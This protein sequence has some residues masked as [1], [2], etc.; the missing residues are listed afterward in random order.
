MRAIRGSMLAREIDFE[1]K[2]VYVPTLMI[3]ELLF[4]TLVA[5]LS[6][7]MELVLQESLEPIVVHGESCCNST[8]GRCT[9]S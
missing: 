8:Y 1:E 7:D 2:W 9:K 5:T 4:S 6:E 3:Q